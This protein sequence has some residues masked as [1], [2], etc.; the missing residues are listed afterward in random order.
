MIGLADPANDLKGWI[1]RTEERPDGLDGTPAC[2]L[3]ATLD[4][5]DGGLYKAGAELPALWHW[6][7][8]MPM[9]RQ[10]ELGDD[11]H[12]RRGGF[13]PP[14]PL[15]RRM[16]AGSRLAWHSPLH[17]GERALRRSRIVS[18]EQKAGRSGPLV[19]VCICHE[20][21]TAHG[22]ALIEAQDLV[23]CERPSPGAPQP[24][25]VPA[26]EGA[27]WRRTLVPD[28]VLLFRYSALTFNG[29]RIHYDRRYAIEVE[30]Y[31]GLVVHGPLCATLM[32]DLVRRHLPAA[33][34]IRFAFKALM[35]VFAGETME[36]CG[37]P[38]SDG[39]TIAL[40]VQHDE[41]MLAMT[42]SATVA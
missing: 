2:G 39:K 19:F 20:Y 12:P 31:R 1:G 15:P 33:R 22:V 25:P 26:P 18:I 8:F 40:W 32:V 16:W 9:A 28:E 3:A 24:S 4:R 29:H 38:E 6:L 7:Y 36:I 27:I 37:R 5:D 11:G 41:G 42:A 17:L 14:V 35:P 34:I 10:S 13:L 23:Y 21:S 30:G